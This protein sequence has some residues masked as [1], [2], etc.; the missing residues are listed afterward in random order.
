[1]LGGT[2]VSVKQMGTVVLAAFDQLQL[3]QRSPDL[4]EVK[5]RLFINDLG[6]APLKG[7]CLCTWVVTS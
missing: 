2:Q 4:V 7:S 3:V 6:F 5:K 1:M